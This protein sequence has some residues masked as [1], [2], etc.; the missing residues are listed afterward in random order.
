MTTLPSTFDPNDC[1]A[2][3]VEKLVHA[4]MMGMEQATVP[5]IT[6]P[7][8][9]LSASFTMLTRTLE[10]MKKLQAPEDRDTNTREIARVLGELL[11]DYGSV[12]N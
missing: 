8:E 4:A 11:V 5:D 1:D 6:T 10:A 2:W 12:P 3:M 9:I 7:S